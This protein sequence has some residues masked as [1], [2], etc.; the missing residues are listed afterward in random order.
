MAT[1]PLTFIANK[2]ATGV[3][4]SSVQNATDLQQITAHEAS[5]AGFLP[6]IENMHCK[7]NRLATDLGTYSCKPLW[8]SSEIGMAHF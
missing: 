4:K 3:K 7:S 1:Q 6:G 2:Q 8:S 5:G